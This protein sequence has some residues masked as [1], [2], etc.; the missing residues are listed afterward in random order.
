MEGQMSIFEI[1]LDKSNE[2][3]ES[4]PTNERTNERTNDTV[5]TLS[6]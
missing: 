5:R 2:I 6:V 4:A 1:G 3:S